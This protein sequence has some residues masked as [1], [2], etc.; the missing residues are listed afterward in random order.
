MENDG[1]TCVVTVHGIGRQQPP[2]DKANVAGYADELHTIL[3]PLLGPS[4]GEDPQRPNGGPVYVQS[5]YPSLS[6]DTEK[7]LERIGKWDA[8]RSVVKG[9]DLTQTGASI[10]HVALVYS[11]DRRASLKNS[12]T[13][14]V[15]SFTG[16]RRLPPRHRLTRPKPQDHN[17]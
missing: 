13:T 2:D 8:G 11:G 17:P 16:K 5:E 3:R 1:L 4:L 14:C 7:G 6:K 12:A 15:A 10:A 9:A